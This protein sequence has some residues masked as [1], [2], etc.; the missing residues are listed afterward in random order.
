M[1]SPTVKGWILVS[2][3]GWNYS[4][5]FSSFFFTSCV[6]WK[7]SN[8]TIK[9]AKPLWTFL[10]T[11]G[12]NS[13]QKS[14]HLGRKQAEHQQETGCRKQPPS[15]RRCPVNPP[16]TD[17]AWTLVFARAQRKASSRLTLRQ[18]LIPFNR[19]TQFSLECYCQYGWALELEVVNYTNNPLIAARAQTK[20]TKWGRVQSCPDSCM[21]SECQLLLITVH[22]HCLPVCHCVVKQ[23]HGVSGEQICWSLAVRGKYNTQIFRREIHCRSTSLVIP[24]KDFHH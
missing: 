1:R 8:H 22:P 20:W 3:W 7:S 5:F 23:Q 2:P 11:R 9:W 6:Y 12:W 4:W 15:Y 14:R 13:A 21:C 16:H 10:S 19:H 18:T 17:L 24:D